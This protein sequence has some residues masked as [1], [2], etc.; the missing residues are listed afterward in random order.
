MLTQVHFS[1]HP[2]LVSIHSLRPAPGFRLIFCSQCHDK[3]CSDDDTYWSGSCRCSSF[4]LWFC[5]SFSSCCCFTGVAG[6]QPD[7]LLPRGGHLHPVPRPPQL[8]CQPS[9][10][11]PLLCRLWQVL[12][13]PLLL[14]LLHPGGELEHVLL[15][16]DQLLV[17]TLVLHLVLAQSSSSNDGHLC[18]HHCC[19]EVLTNSC[20]IVFCVRSNKSKTTI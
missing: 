12:A 8:C 16:A 3:L 9:H 14:H 1:F 2:V 4:C 5:S 18:G 19:S 17:P 6:V 20:S 13:R 10:L 15:R 11:L 7:S